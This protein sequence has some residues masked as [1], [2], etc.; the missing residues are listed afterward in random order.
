MLQLR[1][2]MMLFTSP[3]LSM[4]LYGV[5]ARTLSVGAL[6]RLERWQTKCLRRMAKIPGFDESNITNRM[7]R[8]RAKG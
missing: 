1:A 7:V 4:V 3:R 8:F 5:A 6:T 2:K